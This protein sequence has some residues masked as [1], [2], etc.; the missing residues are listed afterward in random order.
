MND[1]IL[2]R[3][4]IC[5]RSACVVSNLQGMALLPRIRLPKSSRQ[6]QHL[7]MKSVK[8]KHNGHLRRLARIH[9]I[10]RLLFRNVCTARKPCSMQLYALLTCCPRCTVNVFIILV[11]P[12]Q[13]VWKLLANSLYAMVLL[14]CRINRYSTILSSNMKLFYPQRNRY[15]DRQPY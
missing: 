10:R 15:N 1:N 9:K 12:L 2:E 4:V 5:L 7:R 6:R 14:S 13:R 8:L 3:S 11:C